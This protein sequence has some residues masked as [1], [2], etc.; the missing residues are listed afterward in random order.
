MI[1]GRTDARS[2]CQAVAVDQ[3]TSAR[4]G[5]GAGM[6]GGVDRGQQRMN[7]CLSPA[8]PGVGSAGP[9]GKG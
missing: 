7:A 3:S 4:L 5:F 9:T 2:R 6:V 1:A 8:P